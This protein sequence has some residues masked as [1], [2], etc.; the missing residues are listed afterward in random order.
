MCLQSHM[1]KVSQLGAA[2]PQGSV[3]PA[4]SDA[5]SNRC[6]FPLRRAWEW[7]CRSVRKRG[8]PTEATRLRILRGAHAPQLASGKS[9]GLFFRQ[10]SQ[11]V[12]KNSRILRFP[13][14][15]QIYLDCAGLSSIS[16]KILRTSSFKSG[17]WFITIDQTIS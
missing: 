1:Y 13:P 7:R 4:A 17:R 3:K 8:N 16:V 6:R 10:L 15:E 11:P 2:E 9:I 14:D 12:V 5:V